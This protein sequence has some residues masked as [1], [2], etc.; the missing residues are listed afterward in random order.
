MKPGIRTST[1]L[2]TKFLSATSSEAFWTWVER[3]TRVI[4]L[5]GIPMF[6]VGEFLKRE[7]DRA[8]NTLDFVKRFQDSQLVAQ[9]FVLLKPW[10]QYD[11]KSIE[12][13]QVPK[14]VLDELVIKMIDVSKQ[15]ANQDDL[16]PAI[17][18]L[19]DFYES[20]GICVEISRCDRNIAENYFEDY[21]RRFYCL[22]QPYIEHLREK[23]LVTSYGSRLESFALQK[24]PCGK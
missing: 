4:V 5:L 8:S 19:V 10:M 15:T 13:A 7:Q 24:G 21:A 18:S 1:S 20:L 23:Q 6:F 17:F 12:A 14:S 16:R 11:V 3:L 22:Y 2:T 9:R